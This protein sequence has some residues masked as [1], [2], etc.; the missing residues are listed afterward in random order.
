MPR[1]RVCESELSR[2]IIYAAACAGSL[3]FGRV[4]EILDVSESTFRWLQENCD[5][6][7]DGEL[8]WCEQHRQHWGEPGWTIGLRSGVFKSRRE[9][10]A[11]AQ[12]VVEV[13]EMCGEHIRWSGLSVGRCANGHAFGFSSQGVWRKRHDEEKSRMQTGDFRLVEIK[14]END[15]GEHLETPRTLLLDAE[16]LPDQPGLGWLPPA[17]SRERGLELS[18][19]E[20]SGATSPGSQGLLLWSSPPLDRIHLDED[21]EPTSKRSS[22]VTHVLL[23][24]VTET[25]TRTV[26]HSILQTPRAS[27]DGDEGKRSVLVVLLDG[28]DKEEASPRAYVP[29]QRPSTEGG[30]HDGLDGNLIGQTQ[31]DSHRPVER[32][33]S[34]RPVQAMCAIEEPMGNDQSAPDD[35]THTTHRSRRP[36]RGRHGRTK[37]AR[38]LSSPDPS[39]AVLALAFLAGRDV[40][41]LVLVYAAVMAVGLGAAM[42]W[43]SLDLRRER[44]GGEGKGQG[45]GEEKGEGSGER[46]GEGSGEMKGKGRGERKGKG[47]GERNGEGGGWWAGGGR[48]RRAS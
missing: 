25:S 36:G 30:V 18:V 4:R 8:G 47:S 43:V 23:P 27:H 37:W 39:T 2:K 32:L 14:T 31:R 28:S 38:T 13:C 1:H 12:K 26:R 6:N 15:L 5:V 9:G 46:K 10:P 45:S 20:K 16:D 7:V 48:G 42:L 19:S 22:G 44:A 41:K 24:K 34:A 29:V 11:P 40:A 3:V 17:I 33:A 21:R 35:C